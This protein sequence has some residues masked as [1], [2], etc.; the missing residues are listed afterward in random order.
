MDANASSERLYSQLLI[1]SM[2]RKEEFM[3]LTIET[4]ENE[5]EMH[6]YR[7]IV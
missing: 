7:V 1:L 5:I 3:Q 6:F 4:N 2:L